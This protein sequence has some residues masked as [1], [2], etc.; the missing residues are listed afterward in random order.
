M[1]KRLASLSGMGMMVGLVCGIPSAVETTLALARQEEPM[2]W[3]TLPWGLP[4]SSLVAVAAHTAAPLAAGIV[5][6]LLAGAAAALMGLVLVRDLQH[7]RLHRSYW[8]AALLVFFVRG[9]AFGQGELNLAIVQ[10]VQCAP[11]AEV[12]A[13]QRPEVERLAHR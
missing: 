12:H 3:V 11:A 1:V 13:R 4:S 2:R 5:L 7:D 9:A 10:A 6:G 8:D